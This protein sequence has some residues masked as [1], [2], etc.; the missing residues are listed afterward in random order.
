MAENSIKVINILQDKLKDPPSCDC[1]L[2]DENA[3][4]K[5]MLGLSAK[6]HMENS[7]TQIITPSVQESMLIGEIVT[8]DSSQESK[9][10]IFR[11]LFHGR[12]DVYPVRWERKDG[13][14]GYTPACANEWNRE[15]CKKP[16]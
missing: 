13:K 5:K 16:R 6:S 10:E 11:S 8:K 1:R 3:R 9:I 15:F 14:S 12:D 7:S 2:R 4:L